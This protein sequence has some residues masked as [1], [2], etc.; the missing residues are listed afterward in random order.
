MSLLSFLEDAIAAGNSI[1]GN[2]SVAKE[3]AEITA[4]RCLIAAA[5][6]QQIRNVKTAM[7]NLTKKEKPPST[8]V[9][10]FELVRSLVK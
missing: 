9:F 7:D 6:V 10:A 5:K 4:G 3:A 1:A 8:A 2:L